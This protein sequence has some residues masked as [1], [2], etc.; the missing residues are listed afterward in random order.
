MLEAEET[1]A[2]YF[3]CWNEAGHFLWEPGRRSVRD[4]DAK[5]MRVPTANNL[6]GSE[7]FLPR[8]ERP[9]TGCLTYLP[10]INRTVLAWWGS[11]WDKRGAVNAA[12]ITNGNLGETA[13]WQRF[14][15][16]FRDLSDEIER[17]T[18]ECL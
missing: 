8:P 15:Q 3:G 14:V 12:F 11:P 2:V 9:G 18:I 5:R 10:A 16:H 17:P 7:L 1:I 4:F 13:T 6:D